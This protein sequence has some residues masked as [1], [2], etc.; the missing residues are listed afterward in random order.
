VKPDAGD[1]FFI[2]AHLSALPSVR[3]NAITGEGY[4][5]DSRNGVFQ[6]FGFV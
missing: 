1:K 3:A 5:A 4:G 6:F 2:G